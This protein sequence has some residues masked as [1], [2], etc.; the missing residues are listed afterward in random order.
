MGRSGGGGAAR[1]PPDGGGAG[2]RRRRRRAQRPPPGRCGPRCATTRGTPA[3]RA[4]P[5]RYA[6]R[7][8]VGL[9]H[10]Q[11]HLLH[12]GHRRGRH[13]LRRLGGHALLRARPAPGRCAGS[14]GRAGSSTRRRPSGPTTR[15]P[16]RRRSPSAPATSGSTRCAPTPGALRW[17]LKAP[18]P[19][20]D[21]PARELVGGQR[22]PRPGR[23]PLRRQHR[24][25]GLPH[26]RP[27]GSVRWV[28]QRANSVWTTPAFGPRRDDLL[29][30]ARPVGVRAR[31]ATAASAGRTSTLGYVVASPG[32]RDRRHGLHRLLRRARHRARPGHGR[33][34]LDLRHRT[35]TST[36][37]PPSASAAGRPA[38]STSPRPT[39]RSTR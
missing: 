14:A 9:P 26:Q 4:V 6:R 22:R 8:A 19:P 5:A 1:W 30:L 28:D 17:T 11:G 29:G 33:G 37:R 16:G 12:A 3:P 23:R 31:A 10:R 20:A 15:G 18:R 13:R 21:R 27:A 25:R 36:P 7:P 2:A 34:A 39:A 35:T 38:R 32:G 24:R